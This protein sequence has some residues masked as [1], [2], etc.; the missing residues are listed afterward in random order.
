MK[1]VEELVDLPA[2]MLLHPQHVI[3]ALNS[4]PMLIEVESARY[5]G[6]YDEGLVIRYDFI[7]FDTDGEPEF[8]ESEFLAFTVKDF[9][10]YVRAG[11]LSQVINW[12]NNNK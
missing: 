6:H 1:T 5:C 4:A 10:Q 8:E 11:D 2:E 3:E 9:T 7:G 12:I